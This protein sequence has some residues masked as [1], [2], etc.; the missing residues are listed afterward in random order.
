MKLVKGDDLSTI[1]EGM[2]VSQ[3]VRK[4]KPVTMRCSSGLDHT[5]GSSSSDINTQFL[6]TT[7]S[8]TNVTNKSVNCDQDPVKEGDWIIFRQTVP[9]YDCLLKISSFDSENVGE[10]S[11]TAFLPHNQSQYVAHRSPSS[12]KLYMKPDSDET[13]GIVI[14][15]VI[16]GVAAIVLV[17]ILLALAYRVRRSYQRH[18]NVSPYTSECICV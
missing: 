6:F 3:Y 4:G 18:R 12:I 8:E 14:A 9:P 11:C 2:D 13:L 10:Y 15:Y 17:L 16:A 5:Q 1:E 7:E